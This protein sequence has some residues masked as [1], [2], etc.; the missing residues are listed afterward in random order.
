[1]AHDNDCCTYSVVVTPDE[2]PIPS[3]E[4]PFTSPTDNYDFSGLGSGDTTDTTDSRQPPFSTS[5]TDNYDS[6]GLGS[7]DTTDTTDTIDTTERI[8]TYPSTYPDT[9]DVISTGCSGSECGNT[10]PPHTSTTPPT[11]DTEGLI[12]DEDYTMVTTHPTSGSGS[13]YSGFTEISGSG[14]GYSE[15]SGSGSGKENAPNQVSLLSRRRRRNV[16]SSKQSRSG[17]TQ[18]P[19]PLYHVSVVASFQDIIRDT[20][21]R[22]TRFGTELEE[23]RT[24]AKTRRRLSGKTLVRPPLPSTGRPMAA[25]EGGHVTSKRGV[26]LEDRGVSEPGTVY[27]Y[28]E[29]PLRYPTH[30]DMH[31]S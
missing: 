30:L 20:F 29:E 22:Q 17:H 10:F 23:A 18:E 13:G 3:Q 27:L 6:S 19:H 21:Q 15:M 7:G 31:K 1:M 16:V 11:T 2:T 5:P 8:T 14:S 12:D 4:P 24:V 9:T 28:P 25:P 26:L